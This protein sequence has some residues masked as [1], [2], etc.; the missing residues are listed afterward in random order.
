MAR[1]PEYKKLSKDL[2]KERQKAYTAVGEYIIHF[3][4]MLKVI[5]GFLKECAAIKGKL[6]KDR[7]MDIMMHDSTASNLLQY[8]KAFIYELFPK[9]MKQEDVRKY[10][11][12]I[13]KEVEAAY[14]KRNDIAHAS[15]KYGFYDDDKDDIKDIKIVM[16]AEK[17]K[18][19]KDGLQDKYH[20][21]KDGVIDFTDLRNETRQLM[22]L[23]EK[24][25]T[26]TIQI[27]SKVNRLCDP[28]TDIEIPKTRRR[29]ILK[30]KVDLKRKEIISFE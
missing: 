22:E 16:I 10:I 20:K 28:V 21:D 23:T 25:D 4:M 24:I 18:V 13:F 3:E 11:H 7:I 12:Q 9:Q 2:S 27:G 1:T 6:K 8:F 26:M 15:Y 5:R 14:Q 30:K 19:Y 29:Q 17:F